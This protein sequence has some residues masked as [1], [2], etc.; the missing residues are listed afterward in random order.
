MRILFFAFII[1]LI[2]LGGCRKEPPIQWQEVCHFEGEH[3]SRPYRLNMGNI[4]KL[5]YLW[6]FD[7]SAIYMLPGGDQY[8]W[9]KL[10]GLSWNA[11]T[12]H[13]NSAMVGWRYIGDAE[14]QLNAYFHIDGEVWYTEELT[15]IP[16]GEIFY[17]SIIRNG[18]GSVTVD[19]NGHQTDV[20]FGECCDDDD[21]REIHSW[22]GGNQTA[23]HLI[24]FERKFTHINN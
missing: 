10:T 15:A 20:F 2:P 4:E 9:N 22:F 16:I 14:I 17:T 13:K 24:C 8:D 1:A 3:K 12:N 6:E 18:D 11:F 23:P 7:E 19:A 21:S 5:S